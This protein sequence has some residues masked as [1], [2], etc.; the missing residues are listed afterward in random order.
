VM[1]LREHPEPGPARP[2]TRVLAFQRV[3]QLDA[4]SLL[5]RVLGLHRIPAQHW[6]R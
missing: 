4:T 3:G 5:G 1:V 6:C 2:S